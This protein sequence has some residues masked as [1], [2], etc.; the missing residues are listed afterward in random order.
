VR[1]ERRLTPRG[2]GAMIN[3]R[4]GGM[5]LG[6]EVFTGRPEERKK[7]ARGGRWIFDSIVCIND[8]GVL[9]QSYST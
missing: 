6:Q 7:M 5:A 9:W 2:G 8:S 1:V 3:R 4:A